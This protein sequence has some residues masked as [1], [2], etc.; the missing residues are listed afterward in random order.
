MKIACSRT[1]RFGAARKPE[2]A[3]TMIEVAISIA[4]VAFGLVAIIGVLPTGFQV[5]QKNRADTIIDA[6]GQVWLQALSSG[7]AGL[8]YLTNHVQVLQRV[9]G[10]PLRTNS[11]T[12]GPGF[13]N[14][15]EIVGLLTTPA[16][17]YLNATNWTNMAFA[18]AYVRAITGSAADLAPQNQMPFVYRLRVDVT[19]VNIWDGRRGFPLPYIRA[20]TNYTAYPAGSLQYQERSKVYWNIANLAN[21]LY[22]LRLTFQWP[23]YVTGSGSTV[24]NNQ[25]IFSTLVSGSLFH[26]ND[27]RLGE[28]LNFLRPLQYASAQ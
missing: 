14:G 3:F 18:Q 25:R 5:Q 12:F 8:D 11:F 4:V 24:G 28:K 17:V 21:N 6:D 23:V 2:T 22:R 13:T 26:T 20:Y 9:E 27:V 7:A 1:V 19:P 16:A 15:Y 10:F